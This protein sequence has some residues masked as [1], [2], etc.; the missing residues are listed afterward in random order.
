EFDF[1]SLPL[2]ERTFVFHSSG[3]TAQRPSRHFHNAESL[4]I[5]EAFLLPWFKA[6]LLPDGKAID[7]VTLTPS[8]ALAPHSSLA[9]MCDTC[10]RDLRSRDS[11]FAGQVHGLAAWLRDLDWRLDS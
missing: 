10:R 6:H 1:S 2:A 3:T 4:A 9:R 5:Y 7:F 8:P 11:Q